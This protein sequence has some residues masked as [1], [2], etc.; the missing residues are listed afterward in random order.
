MSTT[1]RY[2]RAL[3][4][5]PNLRIAVS[6]VDALTALVRPDDR[7]CAS[8]VWELILKPLVSPLIGWERGYPPLSAADPTSGLPQPVRL[9]ELL[10][11]PSERRRPA[12]TDTER[13][14]RSNEA[15]DGFTD[16][17]LRRLDDAD[18]GNGHGIGRAIEDPA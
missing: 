16:P 4:A 6:V 13:W 12:S 11:E 3:A 10:A 17:L 7:L 14:L 5:E 18:P 1:D 2:Q 8:C 9:S 15:W